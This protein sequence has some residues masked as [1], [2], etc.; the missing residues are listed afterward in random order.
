MNHAFT[1]TI[2][3]ILQKN[4]KT[5][6]ESILESSILLSYINRK[7]KSAGKG[8]KTRASYASLFAIYVLVE[9][10]IKHGYEKSGKYSVYEGAKYSDLL[11]RQRELPGG[12]MLQNHAL[13]S[14][15][16]EEFKKY[17]PTVESQV[18]IRDLKSK[19]YWINESLLKTVING[20][21]VNIAASII[22]IIDAYIS[23]K[24]STLNDFLKKCDELSSNPKKSEEKEVFEFVSDLLTPT[25]DARLFEI[26][27]Y[28][29]L[30]AEYGTRTIWQGEEH[31][32]VKE[33]ALELFKT[34]RTNANDGGIDFI[35]KPIGRF[36]QV[37]ETLDLNKYFLDIDKVQRFPITFVIKTEKS[38]QVIQKSIKKG[39]KQKFNDDLVV[40]KYMQA[41]EEI[42]NLP[43]LRTYLDKVVS[44]KGASDLIN[45]ISKQARTEFNS[46]QINH[47][48]DWQR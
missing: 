48:V 31:G 38:I 26:V 8:S 27:S 16:N 29:I 20:K 7:T 19:K 21:T 12:A 6:G 3:A 10:Y 9:D 41:I 46:V 33:V 42:I 2:K 17:N 4:L 40:E 47:T 30:K 15:L 22:E 45:E 43:L 32:A 39:A 34:G 37:T 14:R 18:V 28:A 13:N 11:T 25:T 5:S 35:M 36:F 44:S 24:Q 23:V 1:E